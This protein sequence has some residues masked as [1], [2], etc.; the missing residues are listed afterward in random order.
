MTTS[1]PIADFARELSTE[2][3]RL[4]GNGSGPI[5]PVFIR[6]SFGHLA[7]Q[8]MANGVPLEEALSTASG[9]MLNDCSE[10]MT[11]PCF[12]DLCGIGLSQISRVYLASTDEHEIDHANPAN[13]IA[14]LSALHRINRAATANLQLG[15]ML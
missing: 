13:P 9:V 14:R 1:T 3:H 6:H 4:S 8:A 5:D 11:A 7:A 2:L 10:A 12:R 15:E